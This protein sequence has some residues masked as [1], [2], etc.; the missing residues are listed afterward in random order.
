MKIQS[1]FLAVLAFAAMLPGCT[2]RNPTVPAA[3]ETKRQVYIAHAG[4]SINSYCYSNSLEAV[5]NTL[6]HGLDCMELDLC[7]TSDGQ[8]V[9]WHD[10]NYRWTGAPTHEQF[11]ARKIYD[12]F[13]PIDFL[14]MDSILTANPGLTLVTDKISNPAIIDQW[15]G[16][17]KNRLWVECFSD[18]D[19][20][21]L[22]QMGY[23]VWASKVPPVRTDQPVAIRNYAFDYRLCP[24]L[25]KCDG[26]CFALF[27][28][29]ITKSDADSLFA[30][31][32]RIRFVYIDFYE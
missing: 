26:D 21:A 15:L 2:H 20:W 10:W 6:T 16:K 9:A 18:A 8:L 5:Q 23:H 12:Q 22:Q 30:T 28:G 7:M 29:T 3:D 13:T 25:S 17:Y 1:H 27:G 14:R 32:P 31:D 11:M 4:G 19:Y 24:D